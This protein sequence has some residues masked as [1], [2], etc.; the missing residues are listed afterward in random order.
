MYRGGRDCDGDEEE[1]KHSEID[2]HIREWRKRGEC[3][4]AKLGD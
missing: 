2:S 4:D 3:E 1:E